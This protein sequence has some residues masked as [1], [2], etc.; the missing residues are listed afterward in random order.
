MSD[1]YFVHNGDGVVFT[2][3]L[4]YADKLTKENIDR[5]VIFYPKSATD[6]INQLEKQK[7]TLALQASPTTPIVKEDLMQKINASIALN[8]VRAAL[9]VSRTPLCSL[10][11]K[12]GTSKSFTTENCSKFIAALF[13]KDDT[14][15][16][17]SS[18]KTMF[19]PL[20]H[21]LFY[22]YKKSETR[23]NEFDVNT[24][25]KEPNDEYK[26]IN[27]LFDSIEELQQ[28]TVILHSNNKSI[29]GEK[30]GLGGAPNKIRILGRIRKIYQEGRK[31][32]IVYNKQKITLAEAKKLEKSIKKNKSPSAA[33]KGR[34]Q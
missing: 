17:E 28:I 16:D 11:S 33:K 26:I 1:E 13:H 7:T 23:Q 4:P 18:G 19:K 32:L 6:Y 29:T 8:Q 9:N 30:F 31:K 24:L 27:D 10:A 2:T 25:R 20:K 3:T 15:H 34:Q 22:L 14:F 5:A 12:V 21:P